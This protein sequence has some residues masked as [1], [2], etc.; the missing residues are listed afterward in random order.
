MVGVWF[1]NDGVSVKEE[2]NVGGEV[3]LWCSGIVELKK[4]HLPCSLSMYI[5]HVGS[6]ESPGGPELL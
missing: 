4:H 2:P 5:E 1:M 6:V 3:P